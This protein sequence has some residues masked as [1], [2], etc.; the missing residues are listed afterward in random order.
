M[1]NC[2]GKSENIRRQDACATMV[3]AWI[4]LRVI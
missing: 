1:A 4:Y 3:L 2:P